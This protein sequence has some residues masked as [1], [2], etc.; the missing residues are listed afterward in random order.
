MVDA[1]I[2]WP[3]T[4]EHLAGDCDLVDFVRA[5]VDACRTGGSVHG[6]EREVGRVAERA[7]NLDRPINHVVEHLGTPELDDGDLETR[8]AVGA[9]GFVQLVHLPSRLQRE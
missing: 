9:A 6:F 2:C 8:I 4:L 3:V 1:R 7:V 5:V